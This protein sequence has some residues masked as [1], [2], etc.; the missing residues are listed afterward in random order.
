MDKVELT[1]YIF[2]KGNAREAFEY[3]KSI[4]G[5]ELKTQTNDDTPEDVQEQMGINDENRGQLMHARL[6][7]GLV[8]L[9]GSDSKGASDK[10]AKVELSLSG[11]D[12]AKLKDVFDKLGEGGK[13][14]MPL[15]KQFWGD[16]FGMVTDKYGVDWM[17]NISV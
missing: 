4:F 17:V 8:T 3:Y 2:F 15:S 7:G 12:E 14:T 6:E 1:P 13:V 10:T 9:M 16:T 11:T 5:G